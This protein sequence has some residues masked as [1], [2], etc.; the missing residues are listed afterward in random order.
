MAMKL[1]RLVTTDQPNLS[2]GSVFAPRGGTSGRRL[3]GARIR[4]ISK[5]EVG[6]ASQAEAIAVLLSEHVLH[7]PAALVEI[8]Q[9]ARQGKVIVPICLVGRGYDY[10][11]AG[12]HLGNLEAGLSARKLTELQQR[13]GALSSVDAPNDTAVSVASLQAVLLATLPRIIAVNWEPEGGKHQLDATVTNVLARLSTQASS[14]KPQATPIKVRR[15]PDHGG[16][17]RAAVR[18]VKA[19]EATQASRASSSRTSDFEVTS[20]V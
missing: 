16:T 20:A 18:L 15:H 11:K 17:L 9:C 19:A 1:G 10:K 3:S 7:E 13:L 4:R 14:T 12:D 2:S 6:R 8:Y 5:E